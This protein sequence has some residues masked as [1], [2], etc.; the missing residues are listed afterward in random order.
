MIAAAKGEGGGGDGGG[1]GGDGG[2]GGAWGSN[3]G[4]AGGKSGGGG[5]DGDGGGGEGGEGSTGPL[6]LAQ[7]NVVVEPW[8]SQLYAH[9]RGT[10]DVAVTIPMHE[11]EVEEPK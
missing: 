5:I 8:G 9:G 7:P 11:G 4:M 1:G 3:D 10:S 2:G 6:K